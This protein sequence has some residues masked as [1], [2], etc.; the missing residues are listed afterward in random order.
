LLKPVSAEPTDPSVAFLVDAAASLI[1]AAPKTIDDKLG[2]MVEIMATARDRRIGTLT[3]DD[4]DG[5][6]V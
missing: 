2:R 1:T 6:Y 4:V 5:G 3:G